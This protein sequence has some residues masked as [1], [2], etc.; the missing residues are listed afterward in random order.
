MVGREIGLGHF[1]QIVEWK[2]RGRM[3]R[4]GRIEGR[5]ERVKIGKWKLGKLL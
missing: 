4:K 2:R 1:P 3:T 5:E